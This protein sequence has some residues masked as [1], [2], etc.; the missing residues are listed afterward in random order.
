MLKKLTQSV[1]AGKPA[2]TPCGQASTLKGFTTITGTGD[3]T[4]P[5]WRNK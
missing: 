1:T 5:C 2:E 3:V 4:L